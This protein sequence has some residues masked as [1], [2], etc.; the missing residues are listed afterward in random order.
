MDAEKSVTASKPQLRWY[1]YRL[2]SLL[3]LMLL[4][5]LGMSCWA[6]RKQRATRRMAWIESDRY[7]RQPIL[8]ALD[9][10]NP[11]P[12]PGLPSEDEVMWTLERARPV[13]DNWPFYWVERANVC[14]AVET[15]QDDVDPPRYYPLI[16]PGQL[17]HKHYKCAVS[18]TEVTRVAWLVTTTSREC[19]EEILVDHDH[20]HFVGDSVPSSAARSSNVS[21]LID[22]ANL[23]V[24]SAN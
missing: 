23:R 15:I 7:M 9:S 16:G 6:V 3:I 14:V 24:I 12:E 10:A 2:R 13:S 17:H 5:S 4:A 8:P 22:P 21:E 18:F 11:G 1:Q 19:E 20:I